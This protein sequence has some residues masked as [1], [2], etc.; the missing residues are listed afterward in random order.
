MAVWNQVS[1]STSFK[2]FNVVE[3]PFPSTLGYGTQGWRNYG[4][5]STGKLKT[6]RVNFSFN[7][8]QGQ[9]NNLVSMAQYF[10]SGTHVS[11]FNLPSYQILNLSSLGPSLR[12]SQS[13]TAPPRSLRSFFHR[14]TV[15]PEVFNSG[16]SGLI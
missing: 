1:I 6:L 9:L 15:I 12:Y 14:L 16:I 5:L 4:G 7:V 11:M 2:P 8:V 3:G 10:D 13:P